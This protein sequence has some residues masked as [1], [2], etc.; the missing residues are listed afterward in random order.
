[1]TVLKRMRKGQIDSHGL[2]ARQ[3]LVHRVGPI[4]LPHTPRSTGE[5]VRRLQLHKLLVAAIPAFAHGYTSFLPKSILVE[6]CLEP[7]IGNWLGRLASIYLEGRFWSDSSF[8]LNRCVQR[9][10]W[11]IRTSSPR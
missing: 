5:A 10:Q 3:A 2:V 8:L 1:M 7:L 6:V 11:T 9:R 4:G